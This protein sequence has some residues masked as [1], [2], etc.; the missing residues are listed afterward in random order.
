LLTFGL[1]SLLWLFVLVLATAAMLG[2]GGDAAPSAALTLG[3]SAAATLGF[4]ALA[5]RLADRGSLVRRQVFAWKARPLPLVLSAVLAGFSIEIFA[6]WW[7]EFLAGFS[8]IFSTK[9]LEEMATLLVEG[10]SG[11]RVVGIV[12]VLLVAPFAEELIFRGFVWDSLE[13][14]LGSGVACLLSS[15]LFALY[16]VDPL[17]VVSVLPLSFLL[18]ALRLRTGSIVPAIAAHFGN[19][20]LAVS[21]L[22]KFG[23]DEAIAVPLSVALVSLTVSLVILV[24]GCSF[25]SRLGNVR[26]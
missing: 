26:E 15:L 4:F 5:S 3:L 22:W 19:N 2:A 14:E 24:A 17:H 21:F 12:L 23:V 9:A 20:L 13:R 16:H 7:S 11:D 25:Q 10:S 1:H 18:G 8:E 6:G